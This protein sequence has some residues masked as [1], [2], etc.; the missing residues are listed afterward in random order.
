MCVLRIVSFFFYKQK[1]AYDMRISDWSSDVCSS[2]LA[3]VAARGRL[4]QVH[5]AV[6]LAGDQLGQPGLALFLGAIGHQRVD[7]AGGQD[8]AQRKAHVRAAERLD[9]HGREGEGQILPAIGAGAV[10]A[11]PARLDEL[12]VRSESTRLN[13]S[14]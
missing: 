4:G 9:H 12:P 8:A 5:R 11:A 1:T 13:S 14:H 3:D 2:D 6:P 10:D 7:R